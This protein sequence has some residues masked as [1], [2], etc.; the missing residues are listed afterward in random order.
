MTK[1]SNDWQWSEI[2]WSHMTSSRTSSALITVQF[3]CYSH[4]KL[5]DVDVLLKMSLLWRSVWTSVFLCC[6]CVS[7]ACFQGCSVE[8][9]IWD[10]WSVQTL[11]SSIWTRS[12]LQHGLKNNPSS[13]ERIQNTSR[14]STGTTID[15]L[16]SA[17]YSCVRRSSGSSLLWS[18]HICLSADVRVWSCWSDFCSSG[19]KTLCVLVVKFMQV[20]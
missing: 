7:E 8:E 16:K 20:Y 1:R 6:N 19:I 11:V 17:K 2:S 18:T 15:C 10:L 9:Q 13:L 12:A 4:T 3:D 14:C 5:S